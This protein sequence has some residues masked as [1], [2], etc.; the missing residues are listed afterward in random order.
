MPWALR[1]GGARAVGA[2][3]DVEPAAR[4]RELARTL[5]FHQLKGG[6]ENAILALP[7]VQLVVT[8]AHGEALGLS[9]GLEVRN[10][11]FASTAAVPQ[12]FVAIDPRNLRVEIYADQEGIIVSRGSDR[13]S[14]ERD[15]GG[16][17]AREHIL[18]ISC[19]EVSTV[20][21]GERHEWSL[22]VVVDGGPAT[23]HGRKVHASHSLY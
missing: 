22:G 1:A 3:A 15:G 20:T 8:F 9:A 12:S 4:H 10:L 2:R 19:L 16:L 17:A 11:L 6:E 7:D 14:L 5:A 13:P 18:Q 23:R 21:V